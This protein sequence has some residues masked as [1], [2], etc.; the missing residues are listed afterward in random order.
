MASTK[1]LAASAVALGAIALCDGFAVP[2]GAISSLNTG[3]AVRATASARSRTAAPQTIRMM[4]TEVCGDGEIEEGERKVIKTRGLTL[5]VAKHEGKTYAFNNK[6]PHL[7]L[8]LK[9]GEITSSDDRHGVCITCPYHKSK[10]SLEEDGKCKVWSE[11]FLG[12]KGTEGLGE[13]IG[14]FVAPMATSVN[15]LKKKAAPAAVYST[16]VENGQIVVDLPPDLSGYAK[17]RRIYKDYMEY[18]QMPKEEE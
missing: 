11:S 7:G 5:V 15:P 4:Q 18:D 14:G 17:G 3:V 8:S 13:A 1:V 6:C 2:S 16:S 12:I 10:F 9:R